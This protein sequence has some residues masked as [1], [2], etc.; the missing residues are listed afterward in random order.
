MRTSTTTH[1]TLSICTQLTFVTSKFDSVDEQNELIGRI[2]AKNCDVV[3][4]MEG[5]GNDTLNIFAHKVQENKGQYYVHFGQHGVITT[6]STAILMKINNISRHNVLCTD[7]KS[8]SCA[9]RSACRG[10]VNDKIKDGINEQ[11]VMAS[12]SYE[13]YH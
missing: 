1:G 5:Q 13:V 4:T 10:L 2:Y 9:V 8:M 3:I 12:R 11:R 7:G 6:N